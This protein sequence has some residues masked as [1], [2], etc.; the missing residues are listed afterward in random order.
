MRFLNIKKARN[1][2]SRM[3]RGKLEDFTG[4]AECLM[5][6]DDLIRYKDAVAED[7]PLIVKGTVD[8]KGSKSNEPGLVLTRVL[9]LPQAAQELAKGLQVLVKLK[10][11]TSVIDALGEILQRSRGHCPVF[12]VVRDEAGRDCILKLGRDYAVNPL[13]VEQDAIELLLGPGS[14]KLV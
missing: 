8:K 11:R 2:N 1:G 10:S 9:T 7:V 12:L 4:L 14:V 3:M 5:W 6:P 13:A